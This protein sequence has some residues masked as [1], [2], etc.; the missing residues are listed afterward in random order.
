M[1]KSR[2]KQHVDE[3]VYKRDTAAW[4]RPLIDGRPSLGIITLLKTTPQRNQ[5][6]KADTQ[7]GLATTTAQEKKTVVIIDE[8]PS[9]SFL[10]IITI[11][12]DR[13][14]QWPRYRLLQPNR[15][16]D[17]WVFSADITKSIA[18]NRIR[19]IWHTKSWLP[20]LTLMHDCNDIVSVSESIEY[21]N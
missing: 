3:Q 9:V 10:L 17:P 20:L 4:N 21:K 12:V 19:T 1:G 5:V 2:L 7:V 11:D 6:D 13:L 14:D 15:D 16:G 8:L 18:L